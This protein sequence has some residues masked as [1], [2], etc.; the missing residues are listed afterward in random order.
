LKRFIK[1]AKAYFSSD[2]KLYTSLRNILGFYPKNI[3][4]YK[5]AFRHKSAAVEVKRGVKDSNERLE[6]LGDAILSAVIAHYLFQTFP[7]K[8]EGF[9]TKMRSRLVSR[10]QLNKLATKVG[11]HQL[12]ESNVE[13]NPRNKSINGDAFEALIGAIYL[14]RGYAIAQKFILNRIIKHHIDI[15]EVESTETDF[16][17]KLI[18][19]VQK[20]K[21]E[22][23]FEV[24]D[25]IGSGHERQYLVEVMIGSKAYGRGQHFSKKKAEQQASEETLKQLGELE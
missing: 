24:L 10:A 20:E 12:I 8:D 3:D 4:L 11:I 5:L 25:E 21:K 18:E 7:F 23:R 6:Y 15:D 2:K 14:D 13:G 17:S 19:W 22:V 9:L 1:P 16:K